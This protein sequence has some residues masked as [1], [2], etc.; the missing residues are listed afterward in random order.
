MFVDYDIKDVVFETETHFAL[1]VKSGFEVFRAETTHAVRCA[2]I[3]FVG[4]AGLNKAI[5]ECK[6]REAL[7]L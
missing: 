2:Q 5:I 7:A 6:K 4:K 3:G 1:K